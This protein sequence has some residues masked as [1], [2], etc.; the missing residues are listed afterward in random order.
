[1]GLWRRLQNSINYGVE[2]LRKAASPAS[3]CFSV[4]ITRDYQDE[5][6]V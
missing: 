6:R 3:I 5:Q 1:M 4:Q 2:P